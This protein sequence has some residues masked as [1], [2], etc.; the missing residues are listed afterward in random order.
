VNF[1]AILA[2]L[3]ALPKIIAL[4]EAAGEFVKQKQLDGFLDDCYDTMDSLNKAK[5][6]EERLAA[7]R[8]LVDLTRRM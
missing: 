7:A 3:Q 5:T 1:A 6:R 4:F 8:K 2:F